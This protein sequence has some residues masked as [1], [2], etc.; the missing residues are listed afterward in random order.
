MIAFLRQ[1]IRPRG[2]RR[3]PAVPAGQRIYAIGDIH[4]RSDLFTAMI[5]AIDADEA[6]APVRTTIVLLGDLIDRGPDSAGVIAA[7]RAWGGG[8]PVRSLVWKRE[9]SFLRIGGRETVLSYPVDPAAFARADLPGAQALMRLAIPQDDLDFLA[10]GED[11][12]MIGDYLFV[13]AGIRPGV[14][15][16]QQDSNDLRWIRGEFTDSQER[17]PH[18]VVH[19]H[20]ISEH[21]EVLHNRIGIDTGAF[22]TGR[23][24]A[25]RLEGTE[26]TF[27]QTRESDAGIVVE[28]GR[29][30]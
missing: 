25:V 20:T 5:A 15:L 8:D 6:D 18:C 4:G 27:L 1:L 29:L 12:I 11:M 30:S 28:T 3:A 10:T 2:A 19:G 21:I 14:P 13:H 23:L 16:D 24:T 17:H 7:A 22:Y 26:Q 9:E